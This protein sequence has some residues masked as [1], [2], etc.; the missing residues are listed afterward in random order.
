ADG[1]RTLIG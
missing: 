1:Y